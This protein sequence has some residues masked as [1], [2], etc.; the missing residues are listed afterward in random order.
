MKLHVFT[1]PGP[2]MIAPLPRSPLPEPEAFLVLPG[3]P[4]PGPVWPGWPNHPNQLPPSARP[5]E[6]LPHPPWPIED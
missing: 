6:R 4:V 1:Q 5:R 3:Y 2:E